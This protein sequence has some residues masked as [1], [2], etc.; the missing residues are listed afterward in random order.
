MLKESVDEGE[1]GM[2]MGERLRTCAQSYSGLSCTADGDGEAFVVEV[3]HDIFHA[4][5]FFADQIVCWHDYIVEFDV[6]GSGTDLSTDFE[7]SH[8]HT[9]M[10]FQW[11]YHQR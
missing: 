3:C 7:T 2:G 6:G 8:T 10:S 11:H 1:L 4:H 9:F 5:A